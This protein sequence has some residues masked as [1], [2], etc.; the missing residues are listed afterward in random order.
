MFVKHRLKLLTTIFLVTIS[1]VTTSIM[2]KSQTGSP[3]L[4]RIFSYKESLASADSTSVNVYVRYSITVDKRNPTLLI[5]PTMYAVA[6]GNKEYAGET[7]GRITMGKPE[8][9]E[10]QTILSVGT[11]P[12]HKKAMSVI[13]SFQVPDLY[14][15]TLIGDNLLSPFNRLNKNLYKYKITPLTNNR[16]EILFIPKLYNTQM[17]SG[18]AVID[19]RSGRIISIYFYG[20]HDMISFKIKA[21]MGKDG[22][23]TLIP[24]VCDI[25]ASFKFIGNRITTFH[26][27]VTTGP[28]TLPDS[29]TDTHDRK[30]MDSIRPE[31]LP[32]KE[33]Y[34]YNRYDSVRNAADTITSGKK[35]KTDVLWDVIGDNLINRIKGNFGA[36]DQGSFRISPILNP[37][38]LGY[39][40]SK[41]I[42]YKM[43]VRGS[44]VF[45][46]NS[47][48]SLYLKAGYSFKQHQLYFKLPLTYTFNKRRHGY[49]AAEIGNGNRITNSSIID[50]VKH[51]SLNDIDWD[52]MNL[53]YF[54]D[55]YVKFITNYD[56]TSK[57]SIQPG[58]LF[59]RRSAVDKSGFEIAGRPAT[60]HSFSPTMQVQVRPW[61]WTGVYITADYE[62]GL[63]G[64]GQSSMSYERFEFDA[65]WMNKYHSLRS[66]SLR[67]GCGFYT[68]KDKNSYFLD[69]ANFCDENIP[70]GWNDDWTGE[71]Q[72][73]NSNWYNASEYYVRTNATYEAPMMLVSRIPF[74]GRIIE[75]ERFYV[76]TLFVKHLHPYIEYGYGFT[77]RVFS[78]G[79]FLATRNNK[80]DGVGC[81]FGFEL[82]KDW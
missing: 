43:K 76:N 54:K 56:I 48:I 45:N 3:I 57:L 22:L 65:S 4:N 59:H 5:I 14:G 37:L 39:S 17:I 41:G 30:L 46:T 10:T 47:D 6:R 72:I 13:N 1:A 55:L 80:F 34:I 18:T 64:I 67:A 23:K 29:I 66:L 61:G 71:F 81:R 12:H 70:G 52:R 2:A 16:S 49:I 21:V 36:S 42:T 33:L 20:E 58:I 24:A 50:R 19:N 78:T 11:I 69:Y 53:D 63:K 27:A 51:E 79:L 77:N 35:R 44:Y 7:F 40:N 62:R 28:G 25:E 38:Y 73:L 32:A 8:T 82:F 15:P 9:A 60:Y 31:P 26:H 74:I 68:S 75:T